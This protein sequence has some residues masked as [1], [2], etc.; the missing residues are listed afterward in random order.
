MKYCFISFTIF[1]LISS[2]SLAFADHSPKKMMRYMK[3][4]SK[5]SIT[6]K[7]GP[8]DI[9]FKQYGTLPKA[10]ET[11]VENKKFD[12]IFGDKFNIAAIVMKGN[13]IVY[14]RYNNK[15]KINS[16]IPLMGLSMSKTGASA[17]VGALLCEGKI[18]SLDDVAGSYSPFL[19]T[20]PYADVTIKNILQMNSGVSPLG[21][22]DVKQFTRHSRGTS[23]KF[24]GKASVRNAL[25]F[26]IAAARKQGDKMNYHTSD[27]L[28]LSVL[29]EEV[30]GM[31]LS[32]FFYQKLYS[33]FG[34]DGYM[35]WTADKMGTTVSF[36]ELTMTAKDWANFGKYLMEEKKSKSCL[37]SFF[38]EGVNNAVDTGNKNGSK[39]GY[40]SWVFNVNGKP[41][42]VLQGHGGQFMVL[43][44]TTDTILLLISMSENY[45]A[46]NLFSNINKF[47]EKLN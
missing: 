10:V 3:A 41:E 9:N 31:P 29:I 43:N 19:K 42:M 18:K 13:K 28:A 40:Q 45:K 27:A 46:G 6:K 14:E 11:T 38:N 34:K 2:T 5:L 37:G 44:E 15:R 47:S 26:Y 35:H 12:Q 21:R 39:Y 8:Y 1:A 32:D 17:A 7:L 23:D 22:D 24:S 4:Y 20:T 36:S 25:N 33:K 16:N 30:A